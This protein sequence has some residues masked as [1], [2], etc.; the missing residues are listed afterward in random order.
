MNDTERT[1]INGLQGGF[2]ICER[3]FLVA[4]EQLG[5]SEDALIEGLRGLLES[6][7]LSRFGPMYHA[8]RLGGA[9]SLVAMEVPAADF[10]RVAE[11]V[12]AYPEVAHNYARDHALNMWFVLATE[13]PER[14]DWVLGE[15][16][17]ETGYHVHDMPKLAEYFVGL[18]LEV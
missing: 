3:P 6:G 11:Q 17:R 4:A 10:D 13:K 5:L 7:V 1:I 16:E 18:R 9:L 15:I 2:P 14:K 8:E 12:N